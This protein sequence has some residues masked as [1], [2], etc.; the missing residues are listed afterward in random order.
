MGQPGI[1]GVSGPVRRIYDFH[2]VSL[3][4]GGPLTVGIR[5]LEG[6]SNSVA[7]A[8]GEPFNVWSG[9]ISPLLSPVPETAVFGR[10][11][12]REEIPDAIARRG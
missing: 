9:R 6:C 7:C 8:A 2:W 3:I 1:P 12:D 10:G 11:T 4:E 5:A